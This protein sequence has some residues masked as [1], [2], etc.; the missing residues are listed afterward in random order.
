[1]EMGHRQKAVSEHH[2]LKAKDYVSA[3][4]LGN[5]EAE[6]NEAIRAWTRSYFAHLLRGKVKQLQGEYVESIE[7]LTKAIECASDSENRM[8]AAEAH[9]ARGQ[10]R[11]KLGFKV[12]AER[13]FAAAYLSP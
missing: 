13:D 7:D 2:Y 5:A 3:D 1:M 4:D 8:N 9:L 12:E 10:C 6:L 11:L